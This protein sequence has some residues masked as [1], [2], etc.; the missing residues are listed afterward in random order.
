MDKA[1]T[2][3]LWAKFNLPLAPSIVANKDSK[4]PNIDFDLPWAVKPTL[5]GSSIGISKVGKIED[6]E[7]ALNKAWKYDDNALVEKWID[8]GEYTVALLDGKSLPVIQIVSEGG[9]YDYE[10]KYISNDTKYLCPTNLDKEL[11]DS[12]KS[13]ALEAFNIL[14][15]KN[16][17]RVDF[18]ID[19][20]NNPFLLEVNTVPGMTSHSLVPMAAK[21]YGLSFNELVANILN[22]K[23]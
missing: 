1:A 12:L 15:G 18:I 19:K 10:S 6:F 5:E 8:G 11:E 23:K 7:K 13:I 3:A 14:G 9:F 4:I 22:A 21:A 16:W 20:N 2:K 17:G